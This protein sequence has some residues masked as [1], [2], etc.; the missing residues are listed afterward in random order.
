MLKKFADLVDIPIVQQLMNGLFAT[1]GIASGLVDKDHNIL[2]AAGWKDNTKL[3]KDSDE[4]TV[5]ASPHAG[6]HYNNGI[7][8]YACPIIIE[9]EHLATL[10]IGQFCSEMPRE[11]FLHQQVE[12]RGFGEEPYNEVV[13]NVPILKAEQVELVF[14]F[15]LEVAK[16]LT[17]QGIKTIKQR[18][19]ITFLQSLMDAIPNPI[20]YKDIK[21]VYQ[22]CNQAFEAFQ[23]RP[24][25][26]IIGRTVYDLAPE[27][28][29][30]K[31]EAM[32]LELFRN[33][34]IQSYEDQANTGQGEKR[35]VLFNKAP[36]LDLDGQVIG[37]VGVIIDI[38]EQKLLNNALRSSEAKYKALFKNLING[39]VYF[40]GVNDDHGK[41]ID[42]RI[43]EVNS[44]FE[45]LTGLS[46]R[47]LRG[48]RVSEAVFSSLCPA[49]DWFEI[50]ND[51]PRSKQ[52]SKIECFF[53]RLE[54]WFLISAYSP[55]P[56]FYA[57][58]LSDI[59]EHKKNIQMAQ[60]YAY[61]DCLT[62]LPNRRMFDDRLTLAIA[63]AKRDDEIIAVTFLD[64]DNFKNVNDT[65]G[66]EGGDILLIEVAQRLLSCSREG[67]TVSRLG[68]DEFVLILPKLK[69]TEEAS[70]IALR[71]LEK[72]REAFHINGTVLQLSASVGISFF[73]Q[74]GEDITSLTRNADIAMYLGK[75]QGRN[76]VCYS[77]R[78]LLNF[79]DN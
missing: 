15:F 43:I 58:I 45:N 5:L 26:E 65:L 35:E 48:R 39:F 17:E 38:T 77:N 33:P 79:T 24:K 14:R 75:E 60:H 30:R 46:K 31:N 62:G 42:Y 34:Q 61:H 21:G 64:L 22:A 54:K 32:D 66:H 50:F 16:V 6:K 11:G 70:E 57:L 4:N 19:G 29:A 59:S 3:Y 13:R 9:G 25:S 78:C 53:P 8:D 28:V 1:T 7:L 76:R 49:L 36:Y 18:H 56:G 47:E 71:I 12:Q 51:V 52:A 63:Q 67:D 2:T 20:F 10:F 69:D 27:E 68:G 37:L 23:G 73:P 41:I 74:D 55:Q 44:A 40:E 72:C